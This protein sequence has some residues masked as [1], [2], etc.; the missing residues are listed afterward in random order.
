M[1]KMSEKERLKESLRL[2]N[3]V[4]DYDGDISR[5]GHNAAVDL[6]FEIEEFLKQTKE[7]KG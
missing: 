5:M 1:Y 4:F 2:L 3:I 6:L 7:K